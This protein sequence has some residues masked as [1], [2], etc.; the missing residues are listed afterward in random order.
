MNLSKNLFKIMIAILLLLSS[1]VGVLANIPTGP[2]ITYNSTETN[3][4]SISQL[5]N[6]SG[7]SFTT[8]VLNVT[9]QN[10]KWKAYVGNVTGKQ[11]LDD[12]L[13]RTIFD[14]TQTEIT[15]NVYATRN[16]SVDWS[17]LSCAQRSVIYGEESDLGITTAKDDSINSTFT[18]NIH[19][20]FYASNNY[21]TNS[22][23]PAIAT[24]VNDQEQTADES[25]SFQEILIQDSKNVLI[26]TT[27]I[28]NSILGFDNSP[29]DFQMILPDDESTDSS[30]AYY[31]YVELT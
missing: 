9:N 12:G 5:V 30:V 1:L 15:G 13:N 22:T 20:D 26:Y 11:T 10:M 25:A 2:V 3:N 27:V 29:Y 21:I 19:K 28:E 16:A 31:F 23:C 24:Y 4:L 14:W 6:T 18:N 7:G 8:L 17:T